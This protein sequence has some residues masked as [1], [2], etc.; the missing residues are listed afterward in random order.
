MGLLIGIGKGIDGIII[1]PVL[2]RNESTRMY[3]KSA[4]ELSYEGE[5]YVGLFRYRSA[6]YGGSKYK[7]INDLDN[8]TNTPEQNRI[9]I[10][11]FTPDASGWMALPYNRNDLFHRFVWLNNDT[12][13]MNN[14]RFDIAGRQRAFSL[15]T[16]PRSDMVASLDHPS[17]WVNTRSSGQDSEGKFKQSVSVS[18]AFAFC[19]FGKFNENDYIDTNFAG[20]KR[21]TG[22]YTFCKISIRENINTII[23]RQ[24]GFNFANTYNK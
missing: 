12:R 24:A 7:L 13:Y 1:P 4:Y 17:K 8:I 11:K 20:R 18:L 23:F 16:I 19:Y 10:V 3:V 6:G 2:V 15:A 21:V 22:E 5:L 9:K 14:T